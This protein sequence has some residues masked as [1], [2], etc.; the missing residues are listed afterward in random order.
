MTRSSVRS[1]SFPSVPTLR[2]VAGKPYRVLSVIQPWAWR[3]CARKS[4]G[5]ASASAKRGSGVP[6]NPWAITVPRQPRRRLVW[7]RRRVYLPRPPARQARAPRNSWPRSSSAIAAAGRGHSSRLWAGEIACVRTNAYVCD[8]GRP[9]N[10]YGFCLPS[11]RARGRARAEHLGRADPASRAQRE[12]AAARTLIVG[13]ALRRTH[14][15]NTR[16]SAT[17]RV[18]RAVC[19]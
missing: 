15:L 12:T 19:A 13:A 11:T 4:A 1:S 6:A 17:T 8:A 5:D 14:V 18:D 16:K 3:Q 2:L 9:S 10:F 7:L